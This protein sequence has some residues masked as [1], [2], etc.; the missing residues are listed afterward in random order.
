MGTSRRIAVLAATVVVL[1]GALV[2]PFGPV[3]ADQ[4]HAANESVPVTDDTVTETPTDTRSADETGTSTGAE[5]ASE[6]STETPTAVEPTTET[7]TETETETKTQ[8]QTETATPDEVET[9]TETSTETEIP[10]HT[11][12]PTP[13]PTDTSTATGSDTDSPTTTQTETETPTETESQ[14]ERTTATS[15]ESST[16]TETSSDS[17]T[18]SGT[19]TPSGPAETGSVTEEA[20]KTPTEG[21]TETP[22]QTREPT[23]PPSGADT[24]TPTATENSSTTSTETE[25][26]PTE[27]TGDARNSTRSA[28]ESVDE[29]TDSTNE[30]TVSAGQVTNESSNS[31]A[32]TGQ[33]DEPLGET[34]SSHEVV[35][36]SEDPTNV[37]GD[38]VEES[39]DA[40]DG[41]ADPVGTENAT[42]RPETDETVATATDATRA[43][44]DAAEGTVAR[45]SETATEAIDRLEATA[46]GTVNG[47]TATV[48]ETLT[49]LENVT[50][51][52]TLTP[53]QS[54][55]DSVTAAM[56]SVTDT[57][58]SL[59]DATSEVT[60][61]VTE[62]GIL[63]GDA[64]GPVSA[65]TVSDGELSRVVAATVT[66]RADGASVTGGESVTSATIDERVADQVG[67]TVGPG[68]DGTADESAA[69]AGAETEDP[70][71]RTATETIPPVSIDSSE[72]RVDH[73][74]A[75]GRA[76]E[77]ASVSSD[78][79]SRGEPARSTASQNDGVSRRHGAV[80]DDRATA[81][82]VVPTDGVGPTPEHRADG[83]PAR[84]NG[85]AAA[86]GGDR[87]APAGPDVPVPDA[88]TSLV[89]LAV[90]AA[91]AAV[92]RTGTAVVGTIPTL[93]STSLR[94]QITSGLRAV[95]AWLGRLPRVLPLPGYSRYDGSDP[96]E[97]DHRARLHE[98]VTTSP[99]V[100]L[101][102]LVERADVSRSTARYHLR[103]LEHEDVL[104]RRE[105]WGKP[106]V[107]PAG[108]DE[109][110]RAAA[111]QAEATRAVLDTLRWIE[112][113]SGTAIADELERDVS[114]ISHHLDRLEEAGLVVREREGRAVVNRL[115][116]D[117]REAAPLGT[118]TRDARGIAGVDD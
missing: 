115:A 30:S 29:I 11:E 25:S 46:D 21:E 69:T 64:T 49:R 7:E 52:S 3:M 116:T 104:E 37:T 33:T 102:S 41:D 42:N 10:E 47:S 75:A 45:T 15:T 27:T 39:T 78:A 53:V 80:P 118:E 34:S 4:T 35:T 108:T 85:A 110:E 18:P 109:V 62:S 112:P 8:T 26:A 12:T 57:T 95:R 54:P 77:S 87:D 28:T 82:G 86:T 99:G 81:G 101:A 58:D 17:K 114:T 5:T 36:D 23:N 107:F 63:N 38:I 83:I 32:D 92:A 96:L 88:P 100:D 67:A 89:L 103:I 6:T 105:V 1:L 65:L 56:E 44:T 48:T 91:G 76:S 19:E 61:T 66:E 70:I 14:T 60:D 22:T 20:T 111:M 90:V 24:P 113:A 55:T 94:T 79:D 9:E 50:D 71:G 74:H 51:T 97:N 13:T 73:R 43:V 72:D 117:A 93:S 31:T 68:E 16:T 98:V 40:L 84:R 59:T 2:A 106:R